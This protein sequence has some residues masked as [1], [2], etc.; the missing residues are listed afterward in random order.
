MKW[1]ASKLSNLRDH[2]FKLE[3]REPLNKL[4][5]IIIIALD[6]FVLIVLF[7]GLSQHTEQLTSPYEYVPFDCRSIYID[8]E[9]TSTNR[10]DKLQ[11]L[12]LSEY[13]NISY[14]HEGSLKEADTEI[15]H[16]TCAELYTI[17]RKISDNEEL[18]ALFVERD[19]LKTQ[20]FTIE[21][22]LSQ[23]RA[24]YD[25]SLLE[26]IAEKRD[27]NNELSAISTKAKRL[28][29]AQ[30]AIAKK[31]SAIDK[32]LNSAPLVSSLWLKTS[33]NPEAREKLVAEYKH[34]QFWYIFKKLLWQLLFM[35]PIF[36]AFYLWNSR[37]VKKQNTIQTLIST[38][39][40][41]VAA[42]PIVLKIIE[43]LL[44][45]I[46][47][48]ML[49]RLFEILEELHLIAV[50]HYFII[51][52]AV[53]TT[54]FIIYLV[55]KKVF[56]QQRMYQRRLMKSECYSCGL[57]LPLNSTFCPFCGQSQMTACPNCHGTTPIKAAFCVKCG[58]K[59]Q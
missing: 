22:E 33:Q 26:S 29:A 52:A 28:S 13:K 27:Q 15:M 19:S 57:K 38:H 59:Q 34:Y 7:N 39:L 50:W 54:L 37:S 35:L 10:L 53:A 18:K 20:R 46:P 40:L 24:T 45:I 32:Q 16:P 49:Q 21:R 58:S 12:V 48:H 4:S 6:A 47:R 11:P 9:W 31:L 8:N 36:I 56:N 30:N 55:Q 5:L 3:N 25:T 42:I 43:L 51:L 41:V 17:I 14:R 23:E 44:D 1:I 2:L